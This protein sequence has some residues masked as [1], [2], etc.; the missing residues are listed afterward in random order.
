MNYAIILGAGSGTRVKSSKVPKQ[1]IE[2][3]DKPIFIHTIEKFIMNQY[4]DT[5]IFVCKD[6]W[7]DYA[8]ASVNKHLHE[9]KNN[10]FIIAGGD[11]RNGSIFNGLKFL[12]E[13]FKMNKGDIIFTHDSVR[14]FVSD[15]IINEN[16]KKAK[17]GFVV[18]TCVKATDTLVCSKS[19][20]N[21]DS[22]PERSSYW[23]GQ[24][25]QTL[26]YDLLNKI[27]QNEYDERIFK[28]T[29]LCKLA[30][31]SNIKI[32]IAEGDYFNIKI[33][34]DFDLKLAKQILGNKNE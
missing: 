26:N 12:S 20:I 25:P 7:I 32:I 9:F 29:D 28:T 11:S 23:N 13:N 27:Y 33:T 18:D 1:F 5:I 3:N 2:L 6:D 21:V 8:N 19:G 16:F 24:T 22:I 4:I 30:E 31:L 15:K 34:T 17:N 10:I 14:I